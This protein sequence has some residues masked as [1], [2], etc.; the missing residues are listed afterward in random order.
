MEIFW[1]VEIGKYTGGSKGESA[2][3]NEPSMVSAK[4]HTSANT[5]AL[6]G[7]VGSMS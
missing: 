7:Q 2:G 3:D 1:S 5:E 6:N 4:C